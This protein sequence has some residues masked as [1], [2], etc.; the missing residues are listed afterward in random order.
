MN[1]DDFKQEVL[2]FLQTSMPDEYKGVTFNICEVEK[3]NSTTRT[4]IQVNDGS[5]I[6]SNIYLEPAFEHYSK[7]GDIFE[8][9]S[10]FKKAVIEAIK[11]KPAFDIEATKNWAQVKDRIVPRLINKE[12]N[13]LDEI[14][15]TDFLDLAMVYEIDFDGIGTARISD[16]AQEMWG[17]STE[18]I[19]TAAMSNLDRLRAPIISGMTEMLQEMAEASGQ[20]MPE[21][22]A[23]QLAQTIPMKV[24]TTKEHVLGAVHLANIKFLRTVEAVTGG[25]FWI[26]PSSIHELIIA[27]LDDLESDILTE[28]VAEVNANE[29]EP[30][31]VLSNTIYKFENG[32]LS[33]A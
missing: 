1:F 9:Q 12:L 4:A 10:E 21:E 23:E 27:P 24:I 33:I 2:N 17:V 28:M 29:V 11:K 5:E 15:H 30:T 14:P 13:K 20:E 32:E 22:M 26:I 25:G 8:T 3:N 16:I 19:H 6:R 7:T 18:E 31:E